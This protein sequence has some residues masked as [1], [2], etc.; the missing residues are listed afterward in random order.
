MRGFL[1]LPVLQIEWVSFDTFLK[2]LLHEE[3]NYFDFIFNRKLLSLDQ[4]TVQF[5]F[6]IYPAPPVLI[7]SRFVF[8]M[9]Y[10]FFMYACIFLQIFS[11]LQRSAIDQLFAL[12]AQAV[13][14]SWYCN[15]TELIWFLASVKLSYLPGSFCWHYRNQ[16]A[17][18]R[19]TMQ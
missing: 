16:F 5:V 6:G 18:Y 12:I 13:V 10:S 9:T 19:Y 11:S 3:E 8:H 17:C 1:C 7:L 14:A 4:R 2:L 15:V